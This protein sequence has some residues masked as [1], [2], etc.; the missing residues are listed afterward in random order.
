MERNRPVLTGITLS[1]VGFGSS[2]AVVLAGLQSVGADAGQAASGLIVLCLA[3][4]FGMLWLARRHRRP[5][6]LAWS[7]PGAALL[8][9]AGVPDGGWPA[10]VGAFALVGLMVL[11]TGLWPWLGRLVAAI[12]AQVAQAMLAGVLVSL[13]LAPVEGMVSD[14]L[15]TLPLVMLWLGL[16][17][18]APAWSAPAVFAAA[19]I[20]IAADAPWGRMEAAQTVPRLELVIPELTSGA[21]L[22]IALPLYLVTMASQNVPGAA[23]ISSYGYKVPWRSSLGVTGA[24]T[25]LGSFFGGHG[26]NLAAIT[27]AMGASSEAHED[28]SQRWRATWAAGWTYLVLAGLAAALVL[29]AAQARPGLLETVAGLALLTTLGA[30]M[31]AATAEARGRVPAA[32]T[33]LIAASGVTVLGIGA[34]F[35]ALLGGLVLW[36]ALVR[37]PAP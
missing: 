12:P 17:R 20:M 37:R 7:T 26:I 24:G 21:L 5:L 19:L 29:L 33:F 16:L 13:C 6:T 35:W 25:L 11:I 34:A 14:P 15:W 22:G 9:S 4:A 1:L 18:W 31:S 2:F 27:A 28:P 8:V 3:Q 36:A 23:V 30:A 32:A 10:A